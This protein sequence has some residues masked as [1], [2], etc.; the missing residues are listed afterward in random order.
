MRFVSESLPIPWKNPLIR[1]SNVAHTKE[2]LYLIPLSNALINNNN[3]MALGLLVVMT[4][5]AITASLT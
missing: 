4:E 5:W 1:A 2:Y 3:R